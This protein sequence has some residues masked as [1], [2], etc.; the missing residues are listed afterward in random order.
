MFQKH[1]TTFILKINK[2]NENKN[3]INYYTLY[4]GVKITYGKLST[5]N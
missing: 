4:F 5:N 3:N 2:H 1:N